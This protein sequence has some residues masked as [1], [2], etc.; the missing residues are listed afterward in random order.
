MKND[1]IGDP[2]YLDFTQR[3]KKSFV[4]VVKDPYFRD[5]DRYHIPEIADHRLHRPVLVA[6]HKHA[7]VNTR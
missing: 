7:P 3:A 4:R 6:P 2:S 5:N 1:N